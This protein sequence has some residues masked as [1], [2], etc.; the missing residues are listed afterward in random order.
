MVVQHESVAHF[1]PV[2]LHNACLRK[3]SRRSVLLVNLQEHSESLTGSP[4]VQAG[5]Y[6]RRSALPIGHNVDL[7]FLPR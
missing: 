6:P 3:C 4:R 7:G 5:L 2:V 1:D